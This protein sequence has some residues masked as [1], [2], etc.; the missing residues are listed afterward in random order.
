[1]H[2]LARAI[3]AVSFVGLGCNALLGIGDPRTEAPESEAFAQPP[4]EE[5]GPAADAARDAR[6]PDATSRGCYDEQGALPINGVAPSA[7]PGKCTPE[8][9]T[10][11]KQKCL[12]PGSTGCDAYIAANR[13]CAQCVFGALQG[14]NAS[15]TPVPA[16]MPVSADSVFPNVAACAALVLGRPD[17]AVK[18]TKQVVCLQSACSK[19]TNDA[20]DTTC[21]ASASAGI[22]KTLIDK[23]C[24]DA[25]N[26]GVAQWEPTCRG[27]AFDDTF[28]KVSNYLC[29]S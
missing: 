14:D 24:N 19:C 6:V 11:L 7:R 25:I 22:C 9:V 27:A 17:C 5:A 1:M 4:G 23:A 2:V 29:G 28:A 15:T 20:D 21:S 13:D 12:G 8:Q 10:E 26:A 18:M 3:F 16:L